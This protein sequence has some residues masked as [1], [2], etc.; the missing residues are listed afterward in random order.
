MS[1]SELPKTTEEAAGMDRRRF[2]KAGTT[3][4]AIAGV[5][6]CVF[7]FRYLSPNVLYEPSP[8]ISVG[9]PERYRAGSV[10][11]DANNGIFVVRA[12]EGFYALSAVCTHLGCLTVFKPE[13]G[14]IACPCHGSTFRRDGSTIAGPAPKPLPWLKM[15]IDE[16]GSLMVDR[17]SNVAALSEYVS[18]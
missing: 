6:A 1:D 9:K 10:T 8:V 7:G 2:V 11:L 4:L 16:D 5:G 14:E 18:A 17:S 12:T 13:S 3:S 15:W